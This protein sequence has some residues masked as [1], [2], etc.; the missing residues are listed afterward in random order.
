M[1]KICEANPRRGWRN[2]ATGE[3]ANPWIESANLW[4]RNPW[5]ESEN[6]WIREPLNRIC[7]LTPEGGGGIKPRVSPRT[8][9]SA[10][11]SI[12]SAN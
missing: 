5:I 12:E 10:N 1:N 4:I 2:K 8:R 7:K 11:P 3:S 9:G 6:L